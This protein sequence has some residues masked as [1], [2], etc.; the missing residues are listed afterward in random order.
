V[1]HTLGLQV[2]LEQDTSLP[3]PPAE[4]TGW[5][6]DGA[7]GAG[8]LRDFATGAVTQHFTKSLN[9]I[10]GK[11]FKLPKSD[12]LDAMEAFQLSTGRAKDFNLAKI[13]FNDANVQTGKNLFINGDNAPNTGG[14]CNFCHTNAGA[15][16]AS[17]QN[18][19]RNFN[20][21]I[22]DVPNH[23]ARAVQSFPRDG[24][25]GQTP[26]NPNGTFGNGT[27]N[28][29]PVVEAAESPGFFH[30]NLAETL[31]DV[32]DFYNGP[33]F[34]NPAVRPV[35]AQ[36]KFTQRE[37][38]QLVAFM[39]GINVLQNIDVATRELKEILKLGSVTGSEAN[40]RLQSAFEDTQDGI[41]VLNQDPPGR[42]FPTAVSQLTVARNRISLAQQTGNANQRKQLIQD[43]I[44]ELNGART[45][46]ATVAP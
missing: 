38:D 2:S 7:P 21:N 28:T 31:D 34:N 1:P 10:N 14:T 44:T 25:F 4:M 18:Q 29:P 5:S 46:V 43:A 35:S 11:D 19:N 36:F 15:N 20:T 9:R 23:P 8:S 17:L 27:F 40:T 30:N 41:D 12:Q 24:G 26:A 37:L 42:L 32:V 6:G 33:V 13:T 16:A 3:S 22:E 39:R 45:T